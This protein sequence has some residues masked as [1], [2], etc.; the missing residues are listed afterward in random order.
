[1]IY[2]LEVVAFSSYLGVMLSAGRGSKSAV[3][4]HV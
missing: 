4:N 1:M 2:K 3:N